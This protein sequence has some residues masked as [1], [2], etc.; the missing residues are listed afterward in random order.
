M[1]SSKAVQV[2]S[3]P[4]ALGAFLQLSGLARSGGEAKALCQE[5]LVRV[6]GATE[7]RR[8]HGLRHGDIVE[9]A[10]REAARVSG[11]E[12]DRSRGHAGRAP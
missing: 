8:S 1:T 7:T 6:N 9:I 10:G 11:R 2:S 5:G 4:I 3:L 12:A